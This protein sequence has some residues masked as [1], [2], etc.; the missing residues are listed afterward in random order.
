MSELWSSIARSQ[1]PVVTDAASLESLRSSV[2][3]A[4]P[5]N[6][7]SRLWW[8]FA[9]APVTGL[10]L[11]FAVSRQV[12]TPTF[13]VGAKSGVV[14]NM[15]AV[16]GQVL[17]INFADGSTVLLSKGSHAQVAE[18]SPSGANIVLS[19]G[20]LE[21][22][23]V[24]TSQTR[25][26]FNAGAYEILVTGTKF[27]ASWDSDHQS[28]EVVMHEGSVLV[29]GGTLHEALQV[30][31]GETLLATSTEH[32]IRQNGG[33]PQKP[34]VPAEVP[35]VSPNAVAELPAA[36]TSATRSI[37]VTWQLLSIKGAHR[38]SFAL[39][40]KLGVVR[41]LRT[42]PATDLLLFADTARYAQE[43]GAVE[44]AFKELVQRF[45][46]A[47]ESIDA[48]FGLGRIAFGQEDW[49]QSARW[50]ESVVAKSPAGTLA[51]AAWG[52]LMESHERAAN[53]PAARE[54]AQRY[55]QLYPTGSQRSLAERLVGG[56]A[57][58]L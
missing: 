43:A 50:F 35:E 11:W 52:R 49:A 42:L 41:R 22:H 2:V 12:V 18:L 19:N 16:D 53:L 10:F 17:P 23:V 40:T 32:T 47:P 33:P 4:A 51:P 15:L 57:S 8:T 45:P 30:R 46:N 13:H 31:A 28:L 14:G 29:V 5:K 56:A 38:E 25:W 1:E 39:A 24:H 55:L 58:K 44:P 21:A 3:E 9:L 27:R 37:G 7:I 36:D 48:A 26:T 54:S 34:A 20:S 6:E